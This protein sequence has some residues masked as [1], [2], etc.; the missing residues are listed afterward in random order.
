MK[1]SSWV[2]P[3]LASEG[4]SRNLPSYKM[5]FTPRLY[6]NQTQ[7]IDHNQCV[8]Y[9]VRFCGDGVVDSDRS[10]QCDDGNMNS[11]DGCSNT[12]QTE[13]TPVCNNLTVT[14]TSVTNGGTVT[15]TCSGTNATSYSIIA[16]KPD[17][18]TLTSS[19]SAA[20]S[21]I[22]PISPAGTYTISCYINGQ[23]STPAAC[24]K[25]VT[26]TVVNEAVCTG[27][28]ISPTSV[29]NGGN[30][31]YTCT[32][33]NTTSYSV[34]LTRPDGT[35]VQSLTSSTG[36]LT[37]PASPSGV[38]TASCYV[39]G[40]TTTPTVC[41]KTVT[42][43]VINEAV[44]TDLSVTPTSLTNGGNVTYTCSGN[45]V[46]SYSV[47]FT[48]PDGTV[49]QSLTT[50]SG[51]VTVPASPTGSYIAKC[52]VN[53]QTATPSACQKTVSNNE[54]ICTG[55]TVTPPSVVNG[56]NVSY[57][58][59]GNNVSSY[60]VIFKKPDGTTLQ[61]F[62][63]PTGSVAIPATPLGTYSAQCFV[64]G[65]TTTPADCTKTVSNNTVITPTCDNLSVTT[66]GTTVNYSCTGSNVSSYS[67]HQNGSQISTSPSGTLNV[68]YGT[69]TF[70]CYVNGSIT[71][72]SCQKTVTINNPTT[73]A[74]QVVKDDNDNHD[75]FQ[76]I[77]NG[78]VQFT[79]VVRN[80]G[81]EPLE[82]VTLSDPSM[83]ECDRNATETQ[84]MIVNV[85]NR[86][87]RLDPGESFSYLCTR[88]N[89][90][91]GTFPNNVNNIC[92]NGRGTPSG[93]TVNSCD[94]SRVGFDIPNICQYIQ[95]SQ[96]G[97]QANVSCSPNGGY[98]LFV[99][100]GQQVMNTYQNPNGQ[101][102]IT[103]NDG[104]YKIVCL[105][106]GEQSVQPNCQKT[107]TVNPRQDYCTLESTVRYG[108]APLHTELNCR[109]T[110]SFAQCAIHVM[111]DGQPWRTISDCHASMVFTEK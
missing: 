25:T 85:G 4:T 41:Q 64:N 60:S 32:G 23:V 57:S 33:N 76:L 53:G 73:P 19:T 36:T 58:C 106:D 42:N 83:P 81:S 47:V 79:V 15:Y 72:A 50:A 1:S 14:P 5:T 84:N 69:H 109:S 65:Q 70:T 30:V 111:K 20:G 40:Q 13:V 80:P 110:N 45:N 49:F 86:D 22:L 56:G 10:E 51:S 87:Y 28:T 78:L 18:S 68:G 101:F 54:S 24:E 107:I 102:N 2:R 90:N 35:T 75:D 77:Q 66:S 108:G 93:T 26:N 37:V 103:L 62:T 99:L 29:T 63:T 7:Y 97:N 44:C 39:N 21:I 89:V 12:C 88:P 74:I 95:V 11:G 17:G 8:F 55:L 34:V 98:K 104:T 96:S 31:T 82:N 67:I 43:T 52:Y 3:D 105:R 94:T 46:S 92:V 100:Q 71:S 9:Y 27:L 91:Q 38:Y 48:K 6:T 59:T 16:K 61:S